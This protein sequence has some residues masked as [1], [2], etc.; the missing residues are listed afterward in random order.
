MNTKFAVAA[1]VLVSSTSVLHCQDAK[2]GVEDMQYSRDAY[3]K[4]HLVAITKLEF[5]MPPAAEFKYDRYPNGGPERIQSGEG[6]DFARKD[7]KTWL[8]SEDWGETGEP[9]DAQTAKRLNNWISVIDNRL[10]ADAPLKF[11]KKE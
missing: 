10:N 4:I 3:S 6:V 5:E 1:A 7:G 8:K 2:T 9:V 11:V